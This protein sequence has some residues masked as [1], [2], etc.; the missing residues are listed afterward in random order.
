MLKLNT[1]TIIVVF[2]FFIS[3]LSYDI[4]SATIEVYYPKGFEVWIP[5]KLN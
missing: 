2:L 3:A 4:P 1:I 5:G